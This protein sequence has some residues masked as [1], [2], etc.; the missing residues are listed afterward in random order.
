MNRRRAM[1]TAAGI[2]AGGGAGLLTLAYGFKNEGQS[3]VAPHKIEYNHP[4]NSWSYAPMD[5]E[6]TAQLAYDSY[7]EGSC[8]YATVKSIVAQLAEVYGEPYASFPL[9]MFKYGH[10]GIG[11]YGTVCG[12]VN[13]AAAVTGLIVADKSVQDLMIND[14]FHWYEKEP[15]P[16]FMPSDPVFDFNPPASIS[17]SVL[18]HASNTNWCKA[19]GYVA[20]SNERKER[21]RRLTADV[22]GKVAISLNEVM[23]NKYIAGKHADNAVGT[24]TACHGS[25]GK[26]NNTSVG[27]SCN[28]CHNESVGHKIFSDVHYKLMKE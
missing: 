16:A 9:H 1:K 21:C 24:C 6:V 7:S 4:D 18:C 2:V 19:T 12:A 25:E 22:A 23:T 26:V 27:M 28:S 20:T 3:P 8:M 17:N 10:G 11:G 5:P 15:F 14:I 13:G